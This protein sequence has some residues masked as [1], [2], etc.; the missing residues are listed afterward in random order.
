MCTS[1][2]AGYGIDTPIET[3]KVCNVYRHAS[4]ESRIRLCQCQLVEGNPYVTNYPQ[5]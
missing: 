4:Q 3:M 5:L 1:R 2:L